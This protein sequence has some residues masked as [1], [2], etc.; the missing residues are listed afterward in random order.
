MVGKG[1]PIGNQKAKKL[2]T[3]ELREE[4]YRQYCEYIATG[5]TKEAWVFDHP[6]LSLTS[7]T[8]EKYIRESPSEFP[9]H[10]K[11]RAE[12]KSYEQWIT[13]GKQMMLGE[14]PKCQPVIF[15]MF[16]RNKFGW[17]KE[18]RDNDQNRHQASEELD[19]LRTQTRPLPE[20][21]QEPV[22]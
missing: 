8:M 14:I 7:K 19:K 13:W 1:G 4:A 15:Q 10:H 16:M 11:E 18:S 9:P 21:L 2:T 22:A 12:A 17:D 20:Q 3:K 5:G 6:T